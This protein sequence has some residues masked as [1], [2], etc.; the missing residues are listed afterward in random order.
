M[1]A[2]REA[3]VERFVRSVVPAAYASLR[4]DVRAPSPCDRAT[5]ELSSR[6]WA[7]RAAR[8]IA[9]APDGGGAGGTGGAVGGLLEEVGLGA[10]RWDRGG[11]A[12]PPG[13]DV[14][15][16]AA[17][18][19]DDDRADVAES[20]A[21]DDDEVERPFLCLMHLLHAIDDPAR[22]RD[23]VFGSGD[24]G[25]EVEAFVRIQASVVAR[26]GGGG[27]V[28]F[29]GDDSPLASFD[30]RTVRCREMAEALGGPDG[31][32]SDLLEGCCLRNA[33]LLSSLLSRAEAAGD[34]DEGGDDAR[35]SASR[36]LS[37]LSFLAGLLFP[38]PYLEDGPGEDEVDPASVAEG[39]I[40]WY[41][42]GDGRERVRCEVAKVHRDDYP[43]LYFTVKEE[44]S[45][46]ERQTVAGRLRRAAAPSSGRTREA[47]PH[48]EDEARRERVGQ[49]IADELVVP[50]LTASGIRGE[51]AAEAA[52]VVVSQCGLVSSGLGSVRYDVYRALTAAEAEL[53]DALTGGPP[54]AWGTS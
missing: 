9:I 1:C 51:I 53:A 15:A 12:P 45:S 50:F 5:R 34:D 35:A 16:S 4:A 31:L 36:A 22:R 41:V 46:K 6:A 32:G 20:V 49:R 3:I 38:S 28:G 17:I 8:L 29:G 52:S 42:R 27:G 13:G 11:T 47:S 14:L 44:G 43:N 30:D 2:S 21:G 7:G 40:L 26:G 33:E 10:E 25:R 18:L 39:Q 19:P 24:R 37:S 48:G 54:S 23:L